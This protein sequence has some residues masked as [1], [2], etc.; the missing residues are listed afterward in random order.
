[1]NWRTEVLRVVV[2]GGRDYSDKSAVLLVLGALG[3]DERDE[4]NMPHHIEIAHGGAPGADT[5]AD[6]WAIVNWVPVKVY[7]ADWDKHGKRA[8]ILRN[9]E[10]LEDFKPHMVVAFPGGRG[11]E[12]C[13]KEAR[14]RGITTIGIPKTVDPLDK[15]HQR[16]ARMELMHARAKALKKAA[17]A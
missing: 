14:K 9:I 3:L 1:M 4:Y 2:T 7:P 5:L 15:D 10:M 12:N 16:M 8:G 13:R 6:D 17:T 11:T